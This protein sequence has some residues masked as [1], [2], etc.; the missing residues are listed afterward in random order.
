MKVT[1]KKLH[2]YPATLLVTL[3]M[4]VSAISACACAHHQPPQETAEASSCHST[5]HD[6]GVSEFATQSDHSA[7]QLGGECDCLVRLPVPAIAAKSEDKLAKNSE[8]LTAAE[9]P[10]SIV[11][12]V[13]LSQVNSTTFQDGVFYSR[14]FSFAGPSRAPPRS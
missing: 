7:P 13:R 3:A 10:G 4:F 8:L 9:G 12:S 11:G 5:A 2:F 6:P 1:L 14:Q